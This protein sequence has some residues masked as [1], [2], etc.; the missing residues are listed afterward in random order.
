MQGWV[1][2]GGEAQTSGTPQEVGL[3]VRSLH[4]IVAPVLCDVKGLLAEERG[5]S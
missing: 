4:L 2:N 3:N 1:L 5:E